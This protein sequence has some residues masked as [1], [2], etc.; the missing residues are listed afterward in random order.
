MKKLILL[1]ISLLLYG[2]SIGFYYKLDVPLAFN[3]YDL[4]VV[5]S[6][7]PYVRRNFVAYIS[8]G[9]SLSSKTKKWVLGRNKNWGSNIIDIRNKD[10]QNYLINKLK[11]LRN[12]RGFFFDTIDSYQLVLPKKEWKSYEKAEI[13]F[14]KRVKRLFPSKK[15]ILNR[16]FEIIKDVKNDVFAMV[17]EGMF[18]GFNGRKFIKISPSD[19]RWLINKLR[20]VKRLG[21]KV[22]VIDYFDGKDIKKA[23]GIARKIGALGFIPYVTTPDLDIVGISNLDLY[24]NNDVKFIKRKILVINTSKY[25]LMNSDAHRL[26]QMPLEYMGYIADIKKPNEAVKIKNVKDLYSGIIVVVERKIKNKNFKPWVK[27]QIKKGNKVLFLEDLAINDLNFLGIKSYDNKASLFDNFKIVKKKDFIGYE[28]PFPP[29]LPR[30]LIYSKGALLVIKNSKNQLFSPIA[31]TKW[32]GYAI[33]PFIF[34]T[35]TSDVK[36][37]INP[38]KFFK[39]ALNLKDFPTPDYTTENGMRI[40]FSHLDGDGSISRA[41][42]NPNKLA[43]EVIK[44]EILR[45]YKLP[46]GISFIEGEIEPYG[47]YPKLSKRVM[48]CARKIYALKNVEGA[49]H[50]FSHPFFWRKAAKLEGK[51]LPKG[52][53][54]ERFILCVNPKMI[55]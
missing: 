4:V 54:W 23:K 32:G 16:G 25:S 33:D 26:I 6:N 38:F 48:I 43:C 55:K 42:F 50:T 21:I 5:P 9:E 15:I 22:V 8:L 18:E 44:N 27:N 51:V 1:F 12:F 52:Y 49:S 13:E 30:N 17:A 7:V 45:K 10:Y 11:R 20:Y 37:F 19:R 36:W 3:R 53:N 46:F 31:V 47:L 41:E 39:L 40:F 34:N 35:F 14:I 29:S 28:A 24:G 2:Y